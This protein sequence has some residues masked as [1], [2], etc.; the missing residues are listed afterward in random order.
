[1]MAPRCA[2]AV[3]FVQL[4]AVYAKQQRRDSVTARHYVRV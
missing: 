2:V 1:M 4:P 3:R